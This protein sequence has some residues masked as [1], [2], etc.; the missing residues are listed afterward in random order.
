MPDWT[1]RNA[2]IA[3]VGVLITAIGAGGTIYGIVIASSGNGVNMPTTPPP[4]FSG[5]DSVASTTI[6]LSNGGKMELRPAVRLAGGFAWETALEVRP[7]A[8]IEV[9]LEAK[10]VGPTT[11]RD[12]T[13]GFGLPG[14]TR[15][16]GNTTD[17]ANSNHPKGVNAGTD[18][19][20]SGGIAIG[21]YSPGANAFV[22]FEVAIDP[23]GFA[24]GRETL[25]IGG[26][27]QAGNAGQGRAETAV[28]VR[29]RC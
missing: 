7:G 16:V 22:K 11:I 12:L 26:V 10:N 8:K 29:P 28:L 6:P 23:S 3:A 25:V 15:L 24:C 20:T 19:V 1:K 21:H 17:I 4:R 5:I 18:N 13:I 9:M 2:I 14:K 27:A